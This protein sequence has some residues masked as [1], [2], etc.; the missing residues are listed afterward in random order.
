[1]ATFGR[2][3]C[4]FVTLWMTGFRT[5]TVIPPRLPDSSLWWK[6]ASPQ[7]PRD[8]RRLVDAGDY[9]AAAALYQRG[10]SDALKAGNRVVAL[11]YLMSVG[12]CQLLG[13]QYRAALATFLE[14]RKSASDLE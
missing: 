6:Q 4:L 1:M 14:A 8:A 9:P 13:L 11:K 10:Y 5:P 7:I 12:G 2:S 3:L